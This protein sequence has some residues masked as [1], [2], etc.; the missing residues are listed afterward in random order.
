MNSG[1]Y[2]FIYIIYNDFDLYYKSIYEVIHR[3]FVD[4]LFIEDYAVKE[5]TEIPAYL[6][7]PWI[8][9][10]FLLI[11]HR[12]EVLIRDV[13]K[14]TGNTMDVTEEDILRLR[15][16]IYSIILMVMYISVSRIVSRAMLIG[17]LQTTEAL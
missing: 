3:N 17:L 11:H 2:P 6:L 1:K 16:I 14:N 15:Y 9:I 12:Y 4:K 10:Y 5:P 8:S 13:E 7:H